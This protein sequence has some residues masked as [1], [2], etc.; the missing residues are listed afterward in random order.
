MS[1]LVLRILNMFVLFL[2]VCL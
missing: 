2:V 1:L